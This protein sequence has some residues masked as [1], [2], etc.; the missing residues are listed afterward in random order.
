MIKCNGWPRHKAATLQTWTIRQNLLTAGRSRN[1]VRK[2][3][4]ELLAM[5]YSDLEVS[6]SGAFG[7]S[8]FLQLANDSGMSCS[9]VH[10][11]CLIGLNASEMG[12]VIERYLAD[13]RR[14]FPRCNP[15]FTTMGRGG[16]SSNSQDFITSLASA[17]QKYKSDLLNGR[18]CYHLYSWDLGTTGLLEQ[19]ARYSVPTVIDTY[20]INAHLCDKSI[21]LEEFFNNEF[22]KQTVVGCHLNDHVGKSHVPLGHGVV[23]WNEMAFHLGSLPSNEYFAIEHDTGDDDE[24]GLTLAQSSLN[25]LIDNASLAATFSRSRNSF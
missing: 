13:F 7:I 4:S 17:S 24:N 11:P 22:L 2:L 6:C 15:L 1:A 19:L 5:G 23:N 18:V 8:E 10:L 20:F 3:L 14:V 25:F 21:K 12:M 9:G 16:V